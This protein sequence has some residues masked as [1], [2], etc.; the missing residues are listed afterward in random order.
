[1]WMEL[2]CFHCLFAVF[3]FF[4]WQK[5]NGKKKAVSAEGYLSDV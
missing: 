2:L 3:F 4:W 1:M 5:E